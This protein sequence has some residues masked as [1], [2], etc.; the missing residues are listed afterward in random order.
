MTICLWCN[1]PRR[2]RPEPR[3][4]GRVSSLPEPIRR[5]GLLIETVRSLPCYS[6]R[7]QVEITVNETVLGATLGAGQ[8]R[9]QGS[10][11]DDATRAIH[12]YPPPG[13]GPRLPTNRRPNRK[14][15]SY[16]SPS[17]LTASRNHL[18]SLVLFFFMNAGNLLS[19][20]MVTPWSDSLR[21]IRPVC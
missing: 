14:Y 13:P 7:D 11:A 15:L 16:H 9:R 21:F 19:M 20:S 10:L 17:T 2:H 3:L 8:P 5:L 4:T 1:L 6:C 18:G 12:R